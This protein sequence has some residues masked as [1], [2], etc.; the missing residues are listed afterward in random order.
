MAL[1]QV[2]PG[3][4]KG[5][6]PPTLLLSQVAFLLLQWYQ[7]VAWAL[8]L[9]SHISWEQGAKGVESRAHGWN[10]GENGEDSLDESRNPKPSHLQSVAVHFFVICLANLYLCLL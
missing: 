4:R 10:E 3:E 1:V 5:S 9:W 2:K 6:F 7:H 8:A